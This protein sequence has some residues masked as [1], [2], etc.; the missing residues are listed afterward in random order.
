MRDDP[1]ILLH[2]DLVGAVRQILVGYGVIVQKRVGPAP[3]LDFVDHR[4]GQG[5]RQGA[6]SA[7][8]QGASD[9]CDRRIDLE[10]AALRCLAGS[11]S[12]G[13]LV[14]TKRGGIRGSARIENEFVQRHA[15]VLRKLE[16]GAI[17]EGDV[18]RAVGAGLDHVVP[19]G[20]ITDFDLSN[21]G[22]A[23]PA[24]GWVGRRR[25]LA[26]CRGRR[27]PRQLGAAANSAII[28]WRIAGTTE[29]GTLPCAARVPIPPR[30]DFCAFYSCRMRIL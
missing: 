9:P 21:I 26:D 20:G 15:G 18:D 6:D 1:P 30:R 3:G 12:E 11:E 25:D 29:H 2:H 28:T 7:I 10:T 24:G 14:E 19:A 23:A 5:E 13:A 22:A 17:G 8:L 4:E 16:R 27:G